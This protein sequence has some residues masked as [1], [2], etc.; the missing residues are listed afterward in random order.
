MKAYADDRGMTLIEV[1]LALLILFVTTLV[2]VQA[3]SG[4][5]RL[6]T[7]SRF[8]NE[9]IPHLATLTHDCVVGM[10]AGE[11]SL[12]APGWLLERQ[13]EHQDDQE[14]LYDL[15]PEIRPTFRIRLV[16]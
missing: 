8:M 1:L 12:E 9:A 16:L 4:V 6:E 10:D 2:V 11:P 7:Q 14:R 15:F 5:L 13:N 3:L